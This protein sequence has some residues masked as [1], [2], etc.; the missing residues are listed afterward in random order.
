MRIFLRDPGA[1]VRLHSVEKL[2]R[3]FVAGPPFPV[4]N[5]GVR[6]GSAEPL[7]PLDENDVR[8]GPRRRNR[9]RATG[10]PGPDDANVRFQFAVGRPVETRRRQN[11]PRIR[12]FRNRRRRQ[13]E[14]V[15]L[16]QRVAQ[17]FDLR[18]RRGAVQERNF[19]NRAAP[20][21]ARARKVESADLNF[22][23]PNRER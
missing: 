11:V 2:P 5:E 17:L 15:F 19:R 7:L 18:L 1:A 3:D 16:R 8:P 12:R 4:R 21:E 20:R 6:S 13:I 23:A 10:A 22:L 9:R 14:R